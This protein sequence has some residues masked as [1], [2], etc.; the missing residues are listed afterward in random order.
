MDSALTNKKIS[1]HI[2]W[3]DV[4]KGIGIFLIF[5]GH[6]LYK[7]SN[8]TIGQLIYSFH[9]AFFFILSGFV[10]S[11]K[12][13]NF[14]GFLKNKIF[15]IIIPTFI[16]VT[17]GLLVAIFAEGIRDPISLVRYFFYYDGTYYWNMP[18]WFFTTLFFVYLIAYF[19]PLHKMRVYWK[20]FLVAIFL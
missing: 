18:C 19:I 16:F 13:T 1:N 14:F 3:V 11:K 4:A 6:M 7:A 12:E 10:F 20:I 9:V 15:R 17:I 5:Y 8:P 2:V